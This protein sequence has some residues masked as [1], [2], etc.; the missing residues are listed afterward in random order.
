LPGSDLSG[1]GLAAQ[2]GTRRARVAVFKTHCHCPPSSGDVSCSPVKAGQR[3]V[4]VHP[5]A[6]THPR[7]CPAECVRDASVRQAFEQRRHH[8]G[9]GGGPEC[10]CAGACDLVVT[11]LVTAGVLPSRCEL[12]A[13]TTPIDVSADQTPSTCPLTSSEVSR[14]PNPLLYIAAVLRVRGQEVPPC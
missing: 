4:A 3:P 1:S 14:N 2:S 9:P 8:R 12:P 11:H 6:R 13:R 10:P 5:R 7:L